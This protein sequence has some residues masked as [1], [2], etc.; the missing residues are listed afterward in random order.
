M[1][2]IDK[3][4]K[5]SA[6]LE[7]ACPCCKTVLRVT[8]WRQNVAEKVE[9]EWAVDTDIAVVAQG[10]MFHKDSAGAETSEA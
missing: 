3:T 4:K 10:K 7:V 5:P 8:Y 1:P 2:F 9:P 6:E